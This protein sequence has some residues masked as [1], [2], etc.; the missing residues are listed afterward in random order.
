MK[1]LI[2]LIFLLLA[3]PALADTIPAAA[4]DEA[5]AERLFA[6]VRCVQCQSESIADSDAPIAGEMRREIR[7]DMANGMTDQQIRTSL[8]D[9]YGDYVLFRPRLTRSNLLLWGLPPLIALVGLILLFLRR[10]KPD[11]PDVAPLSADEEKK[12]HQLLKN[13][14]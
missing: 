4:H 14:E 8:Y 7:V 9:H 3:A 2:G 11:A 12:L 6:E 1:R 10:K 13:R 5:R